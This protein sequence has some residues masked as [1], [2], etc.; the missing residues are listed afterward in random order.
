MVL[1]KEVKGLRYFKIH[2]EDYIGDYFIYLKLNIPKNNLLYQDYVIKEAI[3][4]GQLSTEEVNFIDCISEIDENTYKV[5]LSYN[6]H[7][8]K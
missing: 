3:K 6:R 7:T 4:E 2:I 5:N 8:H 1:R